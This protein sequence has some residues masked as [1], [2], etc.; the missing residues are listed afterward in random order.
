MRNIHT[1][2]QV[3]LKEC[4][5]I[6]FFIVLISHISQWLLSFNKCIS[7]PKK[8][9]P[10]NHILWMVMGCGLA[11]FGINNIIIVAS[12]S[13][14]KGLAPNHQWSVIQSPMVQTQVFPNWVLCTSSHKSNCTNTIIVI[15]ANITINIS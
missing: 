13:N 3:F 8:F 12:S 4:I 11:R 9:Y 5:S 10:L 1:I 14:A 7:M 6:S 15:V 2:F